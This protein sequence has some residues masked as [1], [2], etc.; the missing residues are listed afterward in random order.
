MADDESD[1]SEG[2]LK[3]FIDDDEDSAKSTSN[4]SDDSSSDKSIKS[5]KNKKSRVNRSSRTTRS[6]NRIKGKVI[7]STG[8]SCIAYNVT[9]S[10]VSTALLKLAYTGIQDTTAGCSKALLGNNFGKDD[11]HVFFPVIA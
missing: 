7:S 6:S 11:K 4:S 3:D 10:K 5:E 8:L 1:G 9:I 2:S